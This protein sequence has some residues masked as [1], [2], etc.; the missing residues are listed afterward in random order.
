MRFF[1]LRLV[2]RESHIQYEW[3]WFSFQIVS[4]I[5]WCWS[6][7]PIFVS[8]AHFLC[9]TRKCS[10]CV[11]YKSSFARQ[12]ESKWKIAGTGAFSLSC[13]L[14]LWVSLIQKTVQQTLNLKWRSASSEW[15]PFFFLYKRMAMIWH[16]M[17]VPFQ[18]RNK[19]HINIPTIL[20]F[21][22]GWHATGE[23]ASEENDRKSN[24]QKIN[25][26]KWKCNNI[27]MVSNVIHSM[28][29]AKRTVRIIKKP[30]I[31]RRKIL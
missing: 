4:H 29:A 23:R 8:F 28:C 2:C 3:K 1:I 26:R 15:K 25:W 27:S 30:S 21:A 10:S 12:A 13:Y 19:F 9:S 7:K 16:R 18:L 14:L 31:K 24:V 22:K 6:Y 5:V 20:V 11:D 17:Y